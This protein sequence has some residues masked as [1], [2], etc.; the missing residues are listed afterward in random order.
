M[1]STTRA[2]AV[3]VAVIAGALGAREPARAQTA[4]V[5]FHIET[6]AL[7]SGVH[8]GAGGEV[9]RP[10]RREIR[11][12]GAQW[13]QI[14]FAPCELGRGS[15][16]SIRSLRDGDVQTLDAR[17]M[18]EWR[19]HSG[20]FNGD[21]V[22]IVL[23]VAPGDS[24]VFVAIDRVVVGEPARVPVLLPE[25]GGAAKDICG[26]ADNRV[27]W[28]DNRIGRVM[29]IACTAWRVTNGAFL[30]AGHCVDLDP[31]GSGSMLPDGV[32]DTLTVVQF[33]VPPSDSNGTI[34]N[35]P[36]ADQFPVNNSTVQWRF[37][38][39]GQGLGKDYAV[40]KVG[41]NTNGLLAHEVYGFPFRVTR[42]TPAANTTM[43]VTGFGVDSLPSGTPGPYNA[44][45]QTNQTMTG[46]Y[47]GETTSGADIWVQH[48][49]DTEGG[50]SGSPI[51]WESNSLAIGIHT[52]G[53]CFGGGS[54]AGTS[55][56]VDALETAIR[57]IT[58]TSARFV[59]AGHPLPV[60]EDGTVFRPYNTLVEGTDN[61]PVGGIVSVVTGTYPV[62]AGRLFNKL[63]M[64][65]APTGAVLI[66]D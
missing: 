62:G 31:D 57:N 60:V 48:A 33:N 23:H 21:A 32:L 41:A 39:A 44:Q 26:G 56:E 53:G 35:P 37:D 3:G 65:E 42:E 13:L 19:S 54:N 1:N 52:N 63:M 61:V 64:I 29:P 38:G 18:P 51:I 16:V 43:R 46:N 22:E 7:A 12:A 2:L 9:A 20:Y 14:I 49:V 34:V 36:I 28:N 24:G 27:A 58:G 5:P 45:S 40:F 30:T 50:N 10:F 4:E 47:V 66:R 55:F 15:W 11:I 59:D 8:D 17:S 25:S 6:Y